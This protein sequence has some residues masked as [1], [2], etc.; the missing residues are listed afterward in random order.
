[1]DKFDQKI[2]Q[3]LTENARQSV[4]AV[5]DKVGLSRSAVT[6]RIKKLEDSGI[7]RGYQVLLSKTME[8]QVTV[9]LEIKYDDIQCA[10]IAQKFRAIAEIKI[11]HGVAGDTDMMVLIKAKTMARVHAIRDEISSLTGI[12]KI[13]TH[14]VMAEFINDYFDG[15][16]RL[17]SPAEY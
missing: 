5:A 15:A 1:M 2:I 12:K 10:E 9:Y 8:D 17:S 13:K 7:I 4:S 6:D 11:C 14:V 16:E 3:L